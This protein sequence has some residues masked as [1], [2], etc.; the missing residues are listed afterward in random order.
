VGR[1]ARALAINNFGVVVGVAVNDAGEQRAVR[2]T[3]VG[4]IRDLGAP[5]GFH[6]VARGINDFGVVVG[7]AISK[8]NSDDK[9]ALR[10]L[11]DGTMEDLGTLGG[12]FNASLNGINVFGDVIAT[13]DEGAHF[14]RAVVIRRDGSQVDIGNLGGTGPED[15]TLGRAISNGGHVTGLS[16][17]AAGAWRAFFWTKETGMLDIGALDPNS[18]FSDG[19]AINALGMVVGASAVPPFGAPH[20]FLWTSATGMRDLGT[21]GGPSSSASAINDLGQIVGIAD[22]PG[23]PRRSHAILWQP[24]LRFEPPFR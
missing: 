2:W 9:R 13:I 17:T 22:L 14:S 18:V 6:S 19:F 20:A 24:A 11:P 10:W 4:Q 8:T 5:A 3:G 15:G 21:L 1:P 16:T 12:S 7:T 23:T